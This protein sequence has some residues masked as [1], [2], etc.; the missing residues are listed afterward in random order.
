V[1]ILR[2]GPGLS[3]Y[4][5]PLA[6]EFEDAFRVIRYQQRGLGRSVTSGPFDI[7]RQVADARLS[8][9]ST[10]CRLLQPALAVR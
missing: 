3:D 4:T 10:T 2:G 7:D 8:P 9:G 5:A 1:L 6:A